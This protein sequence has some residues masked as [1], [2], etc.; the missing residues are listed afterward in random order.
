M[1]NL[2]SPWQI[3]E[4]IKIPWKFLENF[5][6]S[7]KIPWFSKFLEVLL[8]DPKI[9]WIKENSLKVETLSTA[10]GK[11]KLR[12]LGKFAANIFASGNFFFSQLF[13]DH[14]SC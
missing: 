3:I 12:A 13:W 10:E 1:K 9:P 2:E 4:S 6:N 11:E 7:L 14:S 5:E 8:D